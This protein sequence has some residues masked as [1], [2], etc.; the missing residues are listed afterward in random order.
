MN[1]GIYDYA[2]QIMRKKRVEKNWSQQELADYTTNIS[3]SFIAQVENPHERARLNLEHINQLA[4][5]FGCSPK[6]FLPAEPL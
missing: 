5:A 2:I 6:D 3:R 1:N 4:K